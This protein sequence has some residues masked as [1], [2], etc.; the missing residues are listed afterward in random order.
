MDRFIGV[1]QGGHAACWFAAAFKEPYIIRITSKKVAF[2]EV[3]AQ[4]DR[5]PATNQGYIIL[6]APA[7]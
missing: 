3:K 5:K 2:A 6:P 7:T 1:D 4:K